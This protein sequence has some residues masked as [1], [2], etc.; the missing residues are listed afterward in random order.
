ME[1]WCFLYK[2][3]EHSI[4]SNLGISQLVKGFADVTA[5]KIVAQ[6]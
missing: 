2:I 4:F 5:E 1:T 3:S 6:P